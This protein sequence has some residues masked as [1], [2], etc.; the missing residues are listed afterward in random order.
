MTLEG[1]GQSPFYPGQPVPVELFVGR[2]LEVD[3]IVRAAQ[4]VASGKP[5]AIFVSGDYG[6]G[7]SSL[8]RFIR[9]AVDRDPGI[10]GFHILLG[11][12]NSLDDVAA[13]TV[14]TILESEA[15]RPRASEAIR[16]FLADYVGEQSIFGLTLRL[17]KLRTDAPDISRGYLPFLR[18]FFERVRGEYRGLLLILDEINGISAEPPF[19]QFLKSLV[20]ENALSDNPLPLLLI[21][22]GT[23]ERFR[24][25]VEGHRPAERIFD[26]ARIE[27]MNGAEMGEF[28]HRAFSHAGM[29]VEEEAM[30]LLIRYSGGLP[31]MM[32]LLGDAA[33]WI[34]PGK[35]VN[36]DV[37]ISAILA[38][39]EDV[40]RKFVDQQVYRALRSK[41]YRSTL[42]K[43]SRHEFDLVFRKKEVEKGLSKEEK[44]KFHNFLQ[45]MKK[46]Q[47]LIPGEEMGEYAFR[48][49]LT[50]L[51]LLLQARAMSKENDK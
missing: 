28:F 40:G 15:A 5:Q 45:R 50:R 37:T 31:K 35:V 27:P 9:I 12:S 13:A 23:D 3:R 34:A 2:A 17:D 19:A 10:L 18:R 16:D 47:V 38:A 41:D 26:M 48:D 7:K 33:F 49:R 8:A 11:G 42:S 51:Y 22:C 14:R 36:E 46:L 30:R 1:K 39:S 25:I 24:D 4:Q 43:L 32:H 6:I 29:H 44:G 20:D 21:L